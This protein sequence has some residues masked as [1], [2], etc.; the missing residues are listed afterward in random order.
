[1]SVAGLRVPGL[2][3]ESQGEEGATGSRGEG[4]A[5][6]AGAERRTPASPSHLLPR[7]P[8][9]RPGRGPWQMEVKVEAGEA[10]RVGCG[11]E[12]PRGRQCLQSFPPQRG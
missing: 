2:K 6:G 8:R 9:G 7:G 11:V 1:M 3:A 5:P 10:E 4:R 12:R